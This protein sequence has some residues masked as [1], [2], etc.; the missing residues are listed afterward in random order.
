MPFA[1]NDGIRIHYELEGD[2]PPL[3]LH[4]GFCSSVL[5][6][7]TLG[8]IDALKGDYGLILLDPRGQGQ[9]DK[10]HLV[11]A[12]GPE[13]RVSDVIATL[14]AL[15]IDRA[16]FWGYSL[17][18]RVGFDLGVRRPDR[19]FSLVL[20][21]AQPYGSQPNHAWAEKLRQGMPAFLAANETALSALPRELHERWLAN[22]PKALAAA[23]LVDRPSLEA[24]LVAVNLPTLVYC[25]DLDPAY[26]GARQAA[27]AYPGGRL[28]RTHRSALVFHRPPLPFVRPPF[29]PSVP[30]MGPSDH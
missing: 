28:R 11:E 2:G 12:Y 19:L 24:D 1:T 30:A 10:P 3:V 4:T 16:H 13:H 26:Q 17:G 5:D 14:D 21:G 25:G 29:R 18:G 22:D 23:I 20:G 27:E 9:S 8:Y 6:W 15:E 7:Y